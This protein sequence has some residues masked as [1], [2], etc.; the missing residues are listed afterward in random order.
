MK[1]TFV[2]AALTLAFSAPALALDTVDVV[3]NSLGFGANT[4]VSSNSGASYSNVFSG[5][6]NATFSNSTAV[7]VANGSYELFCLQLLQS[8]G[9]GS[10][11][12]FT[13]QPILAGNVPDGPPGPLSVAGAAAVENLYAST[14]G[15]QFL[16]NVDAQSF[17]LALWDITFDYDGSL[18]SL[19]LGTGSFR[20]R[21]ISAAVSNSFNNYANAA[22]NGTPDPTEL[23]LALENLKVQDLVF[24]IPGGRDIPCV[25]C[26]LPEPGSL[27]LLGLGM[28]GL[29]GRRRLLSMK[30]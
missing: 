14:A 18:A 21:N 2:S 17:Q 9:L 7:D 26:E 27:G 20:A 15:S 16:S 3:L 5:F 28:I 23:T 24:S 29:A 19:G 30:G 4:S 11:N 25:D 1:K 12:V 6:V 13:I 22:V 10:S 8:I